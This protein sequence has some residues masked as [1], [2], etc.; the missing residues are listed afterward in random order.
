MLRELHDLYITHY[1][2]FIWTFLKYITDKAYLKSQDYKA[3]LISY[4]ANNKNTVFC[5]WGKTNS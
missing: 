2:Q 1:S 4:H 5:F 3:N